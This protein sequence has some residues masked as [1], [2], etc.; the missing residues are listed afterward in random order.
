M[1]LLKRIHGSTQH[2]GKFPKKLPKSAKPSKVVKE[3]K[4]ELQEL[5][6]RLQKAIQLEEFEEAAKLRDIIKET[7][8]K[9]KK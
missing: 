8:K 1:P 7:E 2:Y 5:K 6:D 9:N 3:P 4:D